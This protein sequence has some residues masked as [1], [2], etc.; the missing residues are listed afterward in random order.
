MALRKCPK[1]EINYI[2]GDQPY[3][4]VCLRE[5]R[6]V[7]KRG[8][9]EAREEEEILVCTECGEAPAVAGGELCAECLK[10]QKRQAELENAAD[11]SSGFDEPLDD[12]DDNDE[13][14]EETDEDED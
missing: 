14:D 10:E 13:D 6:K 12:D 11:L 3:C 5:M 1:C 8:K 9:A 2:Q 4:D 7:S